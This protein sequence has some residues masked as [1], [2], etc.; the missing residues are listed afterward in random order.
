MLPDLVNSFFLIIYFFNKETRDVLIQVRA[1]ISSIHNATDDARNIL[2]Q[3]PSNFSEI[4][5]N[6]N[7][8]ESTQILHVDLGS[9]S[10]IIS[11]DFLL[12][13]SNITS[14]MTGIEKILNTIEDSVD[15]LE[16]SFQQAEHVIW[17]IPALLLG[18]SV[19]TALTTFGVILAWKQD[20]GVHFQRFMSYG[21]LPIL[22]LLSF[23]CWGLAI[24]SSVSTAISAGMSVC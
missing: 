11:V 13:E 17:V 20:S 16:F 23:I 14:N 24:G 5:P 22:I 8:N 19:L 6:I 12:L 15:T 2:S 1:A 3:T 10:E 18:I 21:A 7:K 4:C 9:L